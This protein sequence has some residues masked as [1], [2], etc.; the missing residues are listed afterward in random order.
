MP[1]VLWENTP[2]NVVL[3][4]YNMDQ[5]IVSS[6]NFE[7]VVNEEE[8]DISPISSG[9]GYFLFQLPPQP[10]GIVTLG[11]SVYFQPDP[12]VDNN[13]SYAS[14]RVLESPNVLVITSQ[15]VDHFVTILT[16]NGLAVDLTTPEE[17]TINLDELNRYGV[18]FLNDVLAGRFNYE[19]MNALRKF[20]TERGGGLVFLG[21]KNSYTLGG[22]E[23]TLI[24]PILP[25]K[26]EPPERSQRE[27]VI[28][29]LVLD[30]SGS[31]GYGDNGK[32][33]LDLAKEAAMR[34][35]ELLRPE[36]QLGI[37]VFS[38]DSIWSF[39][40][41]SLGDGLA[42]REAMDT[43]TT[44]RI[45]GGT[46][47]YRAMQEA[48]QK[49]RNI[50]IS[51]TPHRYILL[52]TDGQS[53]D[54]TE[55]EFEELSMAS[56]LEKIT[57][58]TIALGSADFN[59]LQ[60]ISEWSGGRYYATRNAQDLP[61]IMMNESKAARSENIQNGLINLKPGE[62]QH[63]ILSGI[64]QAN[65]PSM[66]AYNALT[67]KAEEGA[68]DILVSSIQND[69]ILSAW[70]VGLGRVVAWMGDLGQNWT[71][72]WGNDLDE[73]QFWSQIVRYALPNPAL[74]TGQA[75]ITTSGSD[76]VVHLDLQDESGNPLNFADPKFQFTLSDKKIVTVPMPQIGSGTYEAKIPRPDFG[77]YRALIAYKNRDGSQAELIT[78]FSVNSPWEWHPVSSQEAE[79]GR[80]N[81]KR[82]ADLTGGSES[83]HP[84]NLEEPQSTTSTP[85]LG[86]TALFLI[87][88]ILTWPLEIA[89]RR[90][91]LPWRSV[92]RPTRK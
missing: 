65:L 46:F 73:G 41:K 59:L 19:Q 68:E 64:D 20:A 45:S 62:I 36:D 75:N 7:A 16:S 33:P 35:I 2:I 6:L 87:G 24:E 52:L 79:L 72:A 31:M 3:P 11:I 22:Y 28:F 90:R 58:S 25:I 39:P 10:R 29:L 77:A 83:S 21:G 76:L 17:L 26:L 37:L 42:L 23:K 56:Q 78:P 61:R 13:S 57:I 5:T 92:D 69:P 71:N 50:P 38:V 85:N 60:N 70:Q 81:L 84:V 40:I 43:V 63:P 55:K 82:W 32:A 91:W 89:I 67:S 9:P 44:I 74:G 34:A 4:V 47:M 30:N 8:I 18:I 48:F 53:S 54:G 12:N 49:M 1:T 14:A 86:F 66:T 80:S 27:P 88:L 51:V 15:P